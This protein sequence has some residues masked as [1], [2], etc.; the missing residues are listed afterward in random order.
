MLEGQSFKGLHLDYIMNEMHGPLLLI[1]NV[2]KRSQK[3][4]SD[5]RQ[6]VNS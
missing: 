4:K 6:Y 5:F 3:P 2:P 1:P